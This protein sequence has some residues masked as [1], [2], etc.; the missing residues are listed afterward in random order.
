MASITRIVWRQLAETLDVG[1][2]QVRDESSWIADQEGRD[3]DGHPQYAQSSSEAHFGVLIY[4]CPSLHCDTGTPEVLGGRLGGTVVCLP[5]VCK[6]AKLDQL[7]AEAAWAPEGVS[8]STLCRS[9]HGHVHRYPQF[10]PEL[11]G[12]R[13]AYAEDEAR[14]PDEVPLYLFNG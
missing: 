10:T 1:R 8:D 12:P 4:R 6:A 13:R 14:S 9:Q 5:A 3:K 7:R 11:G 2:Q